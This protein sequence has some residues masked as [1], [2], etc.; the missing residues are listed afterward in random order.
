MVL[1]GSVRRS[2]NRLRISAQLI[3][4][5]DGYHIWSQQY[6]RKLEDL[7]DIQEEIG[8][9]IAQT[10]RIKLVSEGREGIPRRYGRDADAHVFYL[11]GLY[12]L[13]R[14]ELSAA[15]ECF[16]GALAREP[17]MAPALAGLAECYTSMAS[18][19]FLPSTETFQKAKAAAE[20]ALEIDDGL[21]D[22]HVELGVLWMA[23]YQWEK[24]EAELRRALELNPG[25]ALAHIY[26]GGGI[27]GIQGRFEEASLHAQR[28]YEADPVSPTVLICFASDWLFRRN[29]D[30]AI[31]ACE[32]VL[33]LDP[34]FPFAY[35]RMG[36]AYLLQGK[37]AEAESAL[38]QIHTPILAS[39][40]LGYCYAHLGRYDEALS[41]L[42]QLQTLPGNVPPPAYQ[43]AVLYLGMGD[44]NAALEWLNQACNSHS[45]GIHFLKIDPIWDPLRHD[46]RFDHLLQKMNLSQTN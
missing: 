20:R 38:K 31:E 35:L 16:E 4:T 37:Y 7:L 6:D 34:R 28:A 44:E 8:R 29:Y 45:Y 2:G 32:R 42:H 43:I 15:V 36:H 17:D 39:G 23:E 41:L 19:G 11:T 10:L 30:R 13:H 21:A 22:A 9:S 24:A 1:E 18:L 27:F 25:H 5:E 33:E 26:Y 3:G 12:R 40:L 14:M 46:P